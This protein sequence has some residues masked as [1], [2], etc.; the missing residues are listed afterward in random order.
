M[1]R[2]AIKNSLY[3]II[4]NQT[5]N[6]FIVSSEMPQGREDKHHHHIRPDISKYSLNSYTNQPLQAGSHSLRNSIA[7]TL[8]LTLLGFSA[9]QAAPGV[10]ELPTGGQITL[11]SGTISQNGNTLTVQQTSDKL[12]GQWNS[13]NIGAQ[14]T[15]N[16]QQPGASSIA[17][18]R[19][20]DQKP[21]EI[22]GRL[23]ANGQ[24]YLL[25]PNGIIFGKTAQV[26]VGGLVASTQQLSDQDFQSGQAHFTANGG[27]NAGH[28]DNQGQI[29]G[30]GSVVAFIAPQVS[31]SGTIKN[32]GGTVALAAGEQVTLD[33]AGDGLVNVKVDKAALNAL[34]VNHGLIQA[35][36]GTVIMTAQ[37]A[38]AV[39][40]NVVNN[41]GLIQAKSL[42]SQAG[43]IILDGGDKGQTRNAG[44]LDVSSAESKGGQILLT[45]N[46]ILLDDGAHLNAKGKTGGGEVLVGGDLHG[47][48]PLRQ[49]TEVEMK[50]AATID[51]NA[52]ET[53]NGGKV[54]LWS[55]VHN[56]KSQTIVNGSINA[57]GGAKSGNGGFIETSGNR[58]KIGDSSKVDTRAA[59]GKTGMWLLDPEFYTIAASGGD[60]TGAHLSALLA[61]NFVT[62]SADRDINVNDAIIWFDHL[63]TLNSTNGNGNININAVITAN[64]TAALTLKVNDPAPDTSSGAININNTITWSNNLLTLISPG[65]VN[66]NAVMTAN[67]NASLDIQAASDHVNIGIN[68]DGSF[69]GRIDF[70]QDDGITPRSG[71]Y[72]LTINQNPYNV[73][74]NLGEL[75]DINTQIQSPPDSDFIGIITGNFALGANIDNASNSFT[76]IGDM[77][78]NTPF[79]GQFD[80]LGH[81]I[82]NLNISQPGAG[83]GLFGFAVDA[84]IRNVGLLAPVIS[85]DSYVGTLLGKGSSVEIAN[86]FAIVDSSLRS[87]D[88]T[89][90]YI[91][92]LIGNLDTGSSLKFSHSNIAVNG[93]INNSSEVGGLVGYIDNSDVTDSFAQGNVTGLN[94]IGGLIGVTYG[95]SRVERSYA[96]GNIATTGYDVGGLLGAMIGDSLSGEKEGDISIDSSFASGDVS[97]GNNVG[98][99]IGLVQAGTGSNGNVTGAGS[100]G[101][102]ARITDSYAIGAVTGSTS[103]GGLVG[104]LMGGNG[105]DGSTYSGGKGGDATIATSFS[106]GLVTGIEPNTTFVGSLVGTLSNG[107]EGAISTNNGGIASISDSYYDNSKNVSL[108]GIGNP[109]NSSGTVGITTA[110]MKLKSNFVGFN[111]SD[112]EGAW[113]NY[114]GFTTPL[115]RTFMTPMTITAN[116]TTQSFNGLGYSGS[117]GVSYSIPPENDH[118]FGILS[119]TGGTNPGIYTISPSG[120]YSDQLGY[121]LSFADGTLTITPGIDVVSTS[122]ISAQTGILNSNNNGNPSPANPIGSQNIL[123]AQ[124]NSLI[125]TDANL[126]DSQPGLRLTTNEGSKPISFNQ[127]D[128]GLTLTLAEDHPD[129]SSPSTGNYS[130]PV[131]DLSSGKVVPKD[132]LII[133]EKP[134]SLTASVGKLSV[135]PIDFKNLSG[136]KTTGT[137]ILA[138]GSTVTFEISLTPKGILV[139]HLPAKSTQVDRQQLVLLSLA[140]AKKNL[141]ATLSNIKAVVFN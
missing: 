21:S 123:L 134:R 42:N 3:R 95:S 32:D 10:N 25:N 139:I 84:G 19:I 106:S 53:G 111:F 7:K 93:S 133:V 52:T 55:D 76:P 114:E 68:P 57:R 78:N 105:G 75:Q 29:N 49:A 86:C 9:V 13:F 20:N 73:I 85:G 107:S 16:F 80:G 91:G 11:G 30:H 12:V 138:E 126:T 48:G 104:T 103:V 120:L 23:N 83:T 96:I 70:F 24:V 74:T 140:T 44:S 118:L 39:M 58:V 1:K 97:G 90:N 8:G 67:N 51:A 41:D 113:I 112:E 115:L 28:I 129:G 6:D 61:D 47:S 116:N 81:T 99:L 82:S 50:A 101:I 26:D 4:W 72:F 79:M 31:N 5:Q 64:D 125:E 136:A 124:S 127:N 117:A 88:G 119:Y 34:A 66:I 137:L 89:G 59:F 56:P 128:E 77:N 40:D 62:I 108:N 109:I 98:G 132:S 18:N 38:N 65:N 92:G 22:L 87:I 37:S 135:N 69:K 131:F 54:V 102:F 63:L 71:N 14:A 45:G 15:V 110:D 17:L 46:K 141:G 130:L 100:G 33:F 94:M 43:R 60:V 121:I 35:D 27:S 2:H 36:A 122:V